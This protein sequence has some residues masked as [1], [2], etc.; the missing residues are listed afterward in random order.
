MAVP[1]AIRL[2]ILEFRKGFRET[3]LPYQFKKHGPFR[4]VQTHSA[5]APSKKQAS[6]ISTLGSYN[7]RLG[8][9]GL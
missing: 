8:C 7:G 2:L 4:Y 9:A 3:I 1:L 6:Q 5:A